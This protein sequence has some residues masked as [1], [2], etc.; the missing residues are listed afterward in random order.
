MITDDLFFLADRKNLLRLLGSE[1]WGGGAG[2]GGAT[3]MWW[4]CF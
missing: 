4:D 2:L 1:V 3:V